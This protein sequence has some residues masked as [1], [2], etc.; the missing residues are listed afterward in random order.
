MLMTTI[1]SSWRPQPR[2]PWMSM[3][4]SWLLVSASVCWV[5]CPLPLLPQINISGNSLVYCPL[6]S[7]KTLI[8]TQISW[9]ENWHAFP[10]E[11]TA[12]KQSEQYAAVWG[13]NNLCSLIINH[14]HSS[15]ICGFDLITCVQHM[16]SDIY[17]HCFIQN[18]KKTSCSDLKEPLGSKRFQVNMEYWKYSIYRHSC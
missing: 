11:K 13:K 3:K 9:Q 8:Y 5:K 6:T 18:Q 10:E 17:L 1:Y 12:D 16:Q 7:A 2:L 14:V 4:F 15:H